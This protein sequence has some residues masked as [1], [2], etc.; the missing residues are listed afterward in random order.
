MLVLNLDHQEAVIETS[1]GD[2]VVKKIRTDTGHIRIAFG[3]KRSIRI[4]RRE[5]THIPTKESANESGSSKDNA[6][7]EAQGLASGEVAD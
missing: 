1:D 7:R 3:A 5:I 6:I 2:I 4:Y